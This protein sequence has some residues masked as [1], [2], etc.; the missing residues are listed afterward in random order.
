M[1]TIT[2]RAKGIASD[3]KWGYVFSCDG[4]QHRL[5]PGGVKRMLAMCMS[6][7]SER[8][9]ENGQTI[10]TFVLE[11]KQNGDI[12]KGDRKDGGE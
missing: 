3:A 11:E 5:T 4:E 10:T 6:Y 9:K 8:A 7:I 2:N 1:A 12:V